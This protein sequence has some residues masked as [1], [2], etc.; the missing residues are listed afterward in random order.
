MFALDLI[1]CCAWFCCVFSVS[2]M[3]SHCEW[4]KSTEKG[5]I[6]CREKLGVWLR[7]LPSSAL[8]RSLYAGV[9]KVPGFW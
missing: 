6:L 9:G 8:R 7:S 5:R 3:D 1:V 4:E 2:V